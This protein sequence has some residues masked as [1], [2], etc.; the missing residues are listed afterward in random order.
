MAK[1]TY[2][3][4]IY[5]LQEGESALGA[6]LR[7][8]AEVDFSCRKGSCQCCMLQLVSGE[9]ADA[10]RRGLR[11][12]L[13]DSGHFLPCLCVPDGDLEVAPPDRSQMV[14]EAIVADVSPLAHGVARVQLEPE[15]M[16]DCAPGQF[17]NIS[18]DGA[19]RSYS[20]ASVPEEDYFIDL[21]VRRYEGGAVSAWIHDALS[22]GEIVTIQGPLGACSWREAFAGAPVWLVGTGTGIGALH[23]IARDALRR[24]HDGPLTILHGA[25]DMDGLYMHEELRALARDHANVRYVG[26]VSRSEPGEGAVS[27]RVTEHMFNGVAPKDAVLY[28]CGNPEM[29]Y[30]ARVEAVRCGVARGR[31]LADPFE[32]AQPYTPTDK[33]KLEAIAPDPDLWDA[34]DQGAGLRAILEDFYARAYADARLAPFFH[35][36]TMKRAISKQY[37]FLADVFTGQRQYFGLRPFNAHH[38]MIIS[39]DLFDYREELIEECARAWGLAEA[40]L[41]RWMATHER[42]RRDIVKSTGRGLFVDGVER[43]MEGYSLET[44]E[45]ATICDGCLCEI[46]E[47]DRARMHRRTGELFCLECGGRPVGAGEV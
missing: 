11:A 5:T 16:L 23:G 25:H 10:S 18:H 29:V 8:G 9:V 3:G 15:V 47:G 39:N 38:W 41:R 34:L 46:V 17:L 26:C 12:S 22:P 45:V 6:L 19:T 2:R 20:I 14:C 7:G 24:G 27:G 31:V 40:P 21:H 30:D 32:P 35:N 1:V 33:A 42:F 44:I 43:M 36:V 13:V 37:A 28:L 4:T